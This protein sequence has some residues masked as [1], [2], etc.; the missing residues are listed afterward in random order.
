MV[1]G[2]VPAKSDPKD[3]LVLTRD[4]CEE[5]ARAAGLT[6]SGPAEEEKAASPDP[7]VWRGYARTDRL[8]FPAEPN[9][10]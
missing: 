8:N 1:L 7:Y 2:K 4:E 6:P 3:L 5:A 9:F 10:L